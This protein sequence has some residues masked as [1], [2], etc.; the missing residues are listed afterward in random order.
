[1]PNLNEVNIGMNRYCGPAVLSIL[2]GKNTDHCAAAIYKVA[3]SYRGEGVHINDLLRA[4]D[5]LGFNQESVPA[6]NTLYGSLTRIV[7]RD[8]MYIVGLHPDDPKKVEGH[9]V[10]IEVEDKKIY[11][12]DNHTKVIMPASQ[13]ARLLQRVK[14]IYRVSKKPDPI[15]LRKTRRVVIEVRVYEKLEFDQMY[16]NRENLVEARDFDD[17]DKAAEYLRGKDA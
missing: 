13:S 10:C 17:S 2:T 11:F 9:M 5:N 4:L 8:G 7:V 14:Y 12:C 3:P 6:G 16:A 1:M 15:L